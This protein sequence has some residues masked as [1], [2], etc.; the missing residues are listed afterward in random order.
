[1]AMAN[2]TKRD[3]R[4]EDMAKMIAETRSPTKRRRAQ[5]GASATLGEALRGPRKWMWFICPR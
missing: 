5:A 1:M 4:A 2:Y 3:Q